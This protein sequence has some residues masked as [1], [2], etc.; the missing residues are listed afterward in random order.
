MGF[1]KPKT[2]V[3]PQAAAAPPQAVT[4]PP[5]TIED[6]FKV[7]KKA[8]DRFTPTSEEGPQEETTS[9]EIAEKKVKRKKTG[10]TETILTGP[11]GIDEDEEIYKKSLLG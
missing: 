7:P 1:L 5:A 4:P 8:E 9:K 3:M 6:K 10:M 2:I 11:Q